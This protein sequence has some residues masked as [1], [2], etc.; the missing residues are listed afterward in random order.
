[1]GVMS[2]MT[3]RVI[4]GKQKGRLE[5]G[6]VEDRTRILIDCSWQLSVV[7]WGLFEKVG[8]ASKAGTVPHHM[9]PIINATNIFYSLNKEK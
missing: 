5:I 9:N 7:T 8:R 3:R 1:M 2:L 6:R 4:S